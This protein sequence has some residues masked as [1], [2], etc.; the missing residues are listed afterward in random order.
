MLAATLGTLLLSNGCVER[1]V[2]AADPT[3]LSALDEKV[4]SCAVE[5][6]LL[7]EC[8]YLG[9]HGREA[10]PFRLYGVGALRV[11]GRGD[12]AD[13]AAPLTA[14]EH[15]ANFL[16]AQGQSFHTPPENNQLVRKGLPAQA[17]GYAHVGGVI[18]SGPD[19]PRVQVLQRWLA[20]Q[21]GGCAEEDA[22]S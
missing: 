7:R 11:I 13:R 22:G 15:H 6:I 5:P 1:G 17:G 9:C 21:P 10:M 19:D 2:D 20:G 18:W 4:F 16:S 3:A 12:S 8:S 14:A